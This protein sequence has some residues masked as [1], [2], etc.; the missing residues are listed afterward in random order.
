MVNSFGSSPNVL[1]AELC[2]D[3]VVRFDAE[4]SPSVFEIVID[5]TACQFCDM[6]LV[7]VSRNAL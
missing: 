1:A 5:P 4:W 2:D 6:R 7:S 3:P